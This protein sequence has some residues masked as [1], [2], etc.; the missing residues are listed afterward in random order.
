MVTSTLFGVAA[1]LALSPVAVFL[2]ASQRAGAIVYTPCL[3]IT[4]TVSR[5]A[6]APASQPP[7]IVA[8]RFWRLGAHFRITHFR[9]SL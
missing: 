8:A 4:L 9:H 6:C 1:L 5:E 2:A 3:I 7:S